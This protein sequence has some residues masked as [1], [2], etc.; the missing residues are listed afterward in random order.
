VRL[1][2]ALG[3]VGAAVGGLGACGDDAVRIDAPPPSATNRAACEE[4]LAAL[5]QSIAGVERRDTEP[6]GAYGAAWGDPPIVLTCGGSTPTDFD[7]TSACTTVNGVDWFIPQEQLET[8]DAIDRTM[9]AVNREPQV[10]VRL[11]AAYWPPA[12][13][14]ADLSGPVTEHTERTGRCQ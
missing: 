2:A 13:T 12:T 10:Q 9:T 7:A 8:S 1:V 11:P 14:M 4:L 3:A 5:P 6:E